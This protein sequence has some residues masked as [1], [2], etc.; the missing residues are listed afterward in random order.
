MRISKG[1]SSYTQLPEG[2]LSSQQFSTDKDSQVP[3]A[4]PDWSNLSGKLLFGRSLLRLSGPDPDGVIHRG[5]ACWEQ[6]QWAGTTGSRVPTWS[7]LL[8][9]LDVAT[10][11]PTWSL[12]VTSLIYSFAPIS[13]LQ[14]DAASRPVSRTTPQVDA[15]TGTVF[16]ATL[17]HALVVAV[18]AADGAVRA[19]VQIHEHPLAVVTVS[20]TWFRGRLVVGVSSVEENVTLMP[21]YRC[22][23]FVG[24][25][26]AVAWDAGMGKADGKGTGTG[27]GRCAWRG[28]ST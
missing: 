19:V 16:F 22:C 12:N 26:V 25:V 15:H 21:R 5:G 8:I 2:R 9:A 3:R 23:G 18:A 14:A 4:S 6:D 11:T 27:R 24:R 20:P 13:A 1:P 17:T 28:G 10:C 7:G